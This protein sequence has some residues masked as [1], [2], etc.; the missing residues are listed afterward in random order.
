[1]KK[2]TIFAILFFC[3]GMCF[4]QAQEL[5]SAQKTKIEAQL[6]NFMILGK[7]PQVVQFVKNYNS[8]PPEHAKGMTQDKW[9]S[10]TVIS[11]EVKSFSKNVLA[12][13]LKT[14]RTPIVAELFVS[15]ANGNK[16]AFFSKTSNWCHK[17]KPKHDVPMSGKTLIGSIEMDESTGKQLCQI[18]FPVLDGGKPIGSIVIG[19]EIGKL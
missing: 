18:A 6:K 13:Y 16:V 3:V 12:E 19:L 17:G 5:S 11:P 2:I 15:G 8:N 1:M 10:L 4:I 14:K 7:D 9:K